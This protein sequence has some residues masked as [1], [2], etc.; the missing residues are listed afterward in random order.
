ML[1][2]AVTIG[3]ESEELIADSDFGSFMVHRLNLEGA[4]WDA[5]A[6]CLDIGK[7]D[8]IS[9][10][11]PKASFRWTR[12]KSDSSNLIE[13]ALSAF[14]AMHHGFPQLR[15]V[16]N[17]RRCQCIST[18]NAQACCS[19]SN[20]LSTPTSLLLCGM[21]RMH[22]SEIVRSLF[23]T[24]LRTLLIHVAHVNIFVLQYWSF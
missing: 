22:C 24:S 7:S 2:M 18:D 17:I 9:T 23:F 13:V 4:S 20:F 15:S 8:V 5:D 14:N 19:P 16:D 12:T 1:V 6:G 21:L 3:G 11:L 10:V